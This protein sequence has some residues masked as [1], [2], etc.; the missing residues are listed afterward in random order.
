MLRVA[1]TDRKIVSS[2][3][4]ESRS[5]LLGNVHRWARQG[6][7]F[8]QLREKDLE[9]RDLAH[10]ANEILALLHG[11]QTKLLMNSRLD[12][13]AATGAHG[14]HLTSH[15]QELTPNH[16][17]T[18]LPS[19]VVSISCHTL[20]DVERANRNGADFILFGPVFEKRVHGELAV[21]GTGLD[22]LES[23]CRESLIPVLALGGITQ[24]NTPQVLEAGASG[25]A[26]IRLF[27]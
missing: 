20:E 21:E 9:P 4:L 26:G 13:A 14:V 11:T 6:I 8:I 19:A 24:A 16:V 22:L 2:H 15:P 3:E 27:L 18:L 10:L 12:V 7:D 5:A 1:I 17:R 23:A 25:I